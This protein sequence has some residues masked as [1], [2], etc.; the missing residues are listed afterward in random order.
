MQKKNTEAV[1]ARFLESHLAGKSI[2][3][4]NVETEMEKVEQNGYI[5][6][7]PTGRQII[8][9]TVERKRVKAPEPPAN[10]ER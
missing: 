1:M 6:Q 5:V 10:R 2:R 9:V 7:R 3:N 8:T 4:V